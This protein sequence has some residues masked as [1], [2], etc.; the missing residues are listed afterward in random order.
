MHDSLRSLSA[1]W[2]RCRGL[3]RRHV[4]AQLAGVPPADLPVADAHSDRPRASRNRSRRKPPSRR[5]ARR[6][7]QR[8]ARVA[9]PSPAS[10]SQQASL[11]FGES[12][13][14]NISDPAGSR[15]EFGEAVA[16]GLDAVE[17]GPDNL[18]HHRDE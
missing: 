14:T 13:G 8:R 18:I 15:S 16:A 6:R 3:L 4:D 9:A 1:L 2:M 7:V 11:T 17:I 5:P 10:T 12:S